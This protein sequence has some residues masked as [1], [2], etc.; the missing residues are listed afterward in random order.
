[1]LAV[2]IYLH[3]TIDPLRN[4]PTEGEIHTGCRQPTSSALIIRNVNESMCSSSNLVVGNASTVIG[5][6]R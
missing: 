6:D 2:L 1:M 3:I 5:K 4:A